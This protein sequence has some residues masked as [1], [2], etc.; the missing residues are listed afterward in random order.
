VMEGGKL[1]DISGKKRK[2]L[3][4]KSNELES[5]SKNKIRDLYRGKSE[6][7]K[8]YQPRT[9]LL[10]SE[11]GDLLADPHK[12]LNRRKNYFCQLLYVYGAGGV[13][14]TEMHT[15]EPF[16]P[17]PSASETEVAIGK[18]KSYKSPGV[19]AIPA[20][21][22]KAGGKRCV[23]RFINLVSLSRREKNRLTSGKRQ[24]WYLFTKIAIKLNVIITKAYH[25]CQ[26]QSKFYLT[27][28]L[29]G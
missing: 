21:V 5:K 10:K 28:F 4:V 18:L 1:V 9:N 15:A 17:E 27:F 14:Q 8:R 12:I 23:R 7:K 13:W 16:V 20:E 6:F 25:C 2:Y 29:L 26:L 24:S 22:I 19:D 3:K 11:W